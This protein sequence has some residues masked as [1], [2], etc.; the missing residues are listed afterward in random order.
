MGEE[1]IEAFRG[2]QSLPFAVG[3]HKRIPANSDFL[4]VVDTNMG[5]NKSNTVKET[6]LDYTT[7]L[8]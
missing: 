1:L 8:A 2:T 7:D 3:R 4:K 6:T 5:Y